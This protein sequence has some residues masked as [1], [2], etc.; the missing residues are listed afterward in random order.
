MK[1]SIGYLF[2]MLLI[3]FILANYSM[4]WGQEG[5][6]GRPDNEDTLNR[7]EEHPEV[8]KAAFTNKWW[9]EDHPKV[10]RTLVKD[11]KWLED[12]PEV[13]KELYSSRAYLNSHPQVAT[14]LYRNRKWLSKHPDVA[15]E[16]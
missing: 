13:A 5:L 1:K 14:R 7:L 6:E 10:V 4:S 9:L 3:A 12:H 11:R 15:I 2:P 16:V 8:A